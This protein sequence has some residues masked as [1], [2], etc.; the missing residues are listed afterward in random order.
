[1]NYYT[2][3]SFAK[4]REERDAYA[5]IIDML[6]KDAKLDSVTRLCLAECNA[7]IARRI[8][9]PLPI[10]LYAYAAVSPSGNVIMLTVSSLPALVWRDHMPF[11]EAAEAEGWRTAKLLCTVEEIT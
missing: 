1:M 10:P 9:Q 2:G 8:H 4:L 5:S 7:E 3:L 11:R 6:P